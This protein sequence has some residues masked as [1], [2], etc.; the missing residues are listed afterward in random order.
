MKTEDEKKL[1]NQLDLTP[2]IRYGV[3]RNFREKVNEN[4]KKFWRWITGK[5]SGTRGV[6]SPENERLLFRALRRKV[7]Q[8][9]VKGIISRLLAKKATWKLIKWCGQH[10]FGQAP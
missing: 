5:K 1:Q 9:N 6:I 4:V 2:A 7:I 8:G 3:D 10:P